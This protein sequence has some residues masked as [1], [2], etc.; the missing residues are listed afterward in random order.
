M[1]GFAFSGPHGDNNPTIEES[2]FQ[3]STNPPHTI[4]VPEFDTLVYIMKHFP[5]II[6]DISRESILDRAESSILSKALLIVQVAWF[7]TNCASR[8]FQVLPLSL[9]EVTTAAHAFCTLITYIVWWPK[10]LNIAAPTFMKE[11]EALEVYAL[12]KCSHVEYDEALKM[13]REM[14]EMAKETTKE[15]KRAAGDSLPL[16]APRA[17][18]KIVLAAN[19]LQHLLPT[20]EPPPL[21]SGFK[22][23][24]SVP[25]AGHYWHQ[26]PDGRLS[27]VITMAVFSIFYGLV[28]FLAWSDAFPTPVE[29]LLWRIASLVETC[30]VFVGV[31]VVRLMMGS[32]RLEKLGLL[33]SIVVTVVHMLASGFII[34]ESCRQVFFLDATAYQLP[35][36]ANYWPHFS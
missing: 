23:L 9:L 34:V 24:G 14:A 28:H 16:T 30:S 15:K 6:T 11:K 12:L 25:G 18:A 29:R 35:L 19:S 1:G 4:E 27:M 7:C 17:S 13:A 32:R 3:I 33:M 10:P 8:R 21:K 36:W 31:L 2:P 26:S 20:P 22:E 5:H